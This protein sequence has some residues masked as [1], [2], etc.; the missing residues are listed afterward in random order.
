MARRLIDEVINAGSMESFDELVAEDYVDRS[1]A[2][3]VAGK[4]PYR[5]LIV[6]TRQTFPDLHM[7]IEGMVGSGD[8]VV[9][10]FR[11][12]G[13]QAGELFGVPPTG[14]RLEWTG[15][16][17]LRFQDGRLVERW[18]ESDMISVLQQLGAIPG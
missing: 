9:L 16:G 15:I 14:R 7:T 3:P 8:T 18:N 12:S 13:T 17:W 6:Q 1:D 2:S 10:R 11:A 5:E 4:E